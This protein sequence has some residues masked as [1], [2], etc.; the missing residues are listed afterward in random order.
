MAIEIHEKSRCTF[1]VQDLQ[2]RIFHENRR[3]IFLVHRPFQASIT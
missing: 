1:T 3:Q 2:S